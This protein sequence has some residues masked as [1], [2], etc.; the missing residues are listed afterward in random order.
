MSDDRNFKHDILRLL[1]HRGP[2][3]TICPSEVLSGDLKQDKAT[4]EEVRKSA[5]ELALEGKIEITQKGQIVDPLNFK[6]PIRLKLC[7]K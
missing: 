1:S 7:L 2:R 6:G 5:S 3:K 4:M